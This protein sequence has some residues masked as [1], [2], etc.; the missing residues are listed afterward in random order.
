M[1]FRVAL[2]LACISCAQ[3][4]FGQSTTRKPAPAAPAKPRGEVRVPFRAGEL[5][6]YD[7]SYSTY[8]TAGTVTADD[9][10]LFGANG[11]SGVTGVTL[12][13]TDIVPGPGVTV[14]KILGPLR[15]NGGPTETHALKAR[16]PAV[17]AIP[18]A[19]PDCTGTDQRGIS[20]PQGAGCD[21]GAFELR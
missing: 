16:S 21:I 20:R 13:S 3:G 17:N 1:R 6:T 15:D 2:V 11:A 9:Y 10:N 7:V 5:L 14:S 19:D 18:S 4:L 12:G 8:V